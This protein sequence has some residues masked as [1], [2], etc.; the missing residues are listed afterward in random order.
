MVRQFCLLLLVAGNRLNAALCAIRH[1][2][3]VPLAIAVTILSMLAILI[4]LEV[5]YRWK[6]EV[7]R[8]HKEAREIAVAFARSI[9]LPNYL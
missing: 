9:D 8:G 1:I 5:D 2:R 7:V 6:K 4:L 3:T